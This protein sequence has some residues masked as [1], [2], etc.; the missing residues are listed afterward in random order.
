MILVLR[1]FDFKQQ[2]IL[3]INA[4]DYVKGEILSQYDDEKVLHLMIFY[5]KS[6]I[7]VKCNY[8]IYDKK[9]LAI[10]HYFEH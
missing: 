5:S 7:S 9:L 3:E 1:H 10:I 4:S 2:T 8:H 6:M